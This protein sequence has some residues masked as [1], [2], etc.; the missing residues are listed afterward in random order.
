MASARSVKAGDR[1]NSV[2]TGLFIG[3]EWVESVAQTT[4]GVENPATGEEI[5]QIQE[6]RAEDVDIAVNKARALFS[7]P[8]FKEMN[9]ME[10]GAILNKLADLMEQHKDDLIALEML[11]TGKT[12]K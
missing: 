2:P 7:D 9:P 8:E 10:R 12:Y 4:F 5:I 3:N 11:D 1:S 6:G